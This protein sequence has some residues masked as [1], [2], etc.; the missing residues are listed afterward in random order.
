M[1]RVVVKHSKVYVPIGLLE[2]RELRPSDKLLWIALAVDAD[3]PMR[4][5]LSGTRLEAKWKGSF[6]RQTC[7][8]S[9]TRLQAGGWY[10]AETDAAGSTGA[11]PE[12]PELETTTVGMPISALVEGN[13]TPRAKLTLMQLKARG[14]ARQPKASRIAPLGAY[15]GLTPNPVREALAVLKRAG[16][17]AVE[18]ASRTT[19]LCLTPLNPVRAKHERMRAFLAK[20]IDEGEKCRRGHH[21][22]LAHRLGRR[23]RPAR[24]CHARV[25]SRPCYRRESRNR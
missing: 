15:L 9:I 5:R 14:A 22:R 17:L 10:P 20:C 13:L 18:Q 1:H 3:L 4:E 12:R 7:V 11:L 16:W 24:Q 19:P 25:P 2:S 8:K 23:Q 21:A 6:C